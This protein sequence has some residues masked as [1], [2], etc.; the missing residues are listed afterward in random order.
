MSDNRYFKAALSDFAFDAA[1]GDSIRH[2]HNSGYTPEEISEYL[3]SGS[4]SADR[5]REVISRY[6]SVKTDSDGGYEYVKEYDSYGRASFIK[7][8]TDNNS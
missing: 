2:L 8:K 3:D 1:F 5:I 6:E 4:L 7:K